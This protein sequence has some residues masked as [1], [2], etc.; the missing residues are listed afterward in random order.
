METCLNNIN[1]SINPEPS[2]RSSM[3]SMQLSQ[4]M[5]NLKTKISRIRLDDNKVKQKMLM[6]EEELDVMFLEYCYIK[7]KF[8]E[9]L[10]I[11]N[12]S[13]AS[14][15]TNNEFTTIITESSILETNTSLFPIP[16]KDLIEYYDYMFPTLDTYCKFVDQ[17]LEPW[18]HT[19]K[20]KLFNSLYWH[21]QSTMELIK[22]LRDQAQK[23]LKEANCLQEWHSTLC[24]QLDWHIT[25]MTDMA[26]W[27]QLQNTTKVYPWPPIPQIW[28]TRPPVSTAQIPI[29]PNLQH[30]IQ[31]TRICCFQCESPSHI[32][33]QARILWSWISELLWYWWRRR[34]KS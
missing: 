6:L 3:P 17:K 30:G 13:S 21:Q 14:T 4:S 1:S 25:T 32:K 22:R 8:T 20:L 12:F 24:Q 2:S 5:L 16:Y 29:Y 7:S 10:I 11:S 28:Q 18:Q 19:L 15:Q 23:S 34:W 31:S 26:L 27:K 9:V 33:W